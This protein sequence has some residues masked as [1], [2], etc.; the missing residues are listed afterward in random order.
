MASRTPCNVWPEKGFQLYIKLVKLVRRSGS[1]IERNCLSRQ[2]KK[3]I[4]PTK[5][6]P[7]PF[8]RGAGGGGKKLLGEMD[9]LIRLYLYTEVHHR[10]SGPTVCLFSN[11][12]LLCGIDTKSLHNALH[13]LLFFSLAGTKNSTP[14]QKQFYLCISSPTLFHTKRKTNSWISDF[15]FGDNIR[16]LFRYGRC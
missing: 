11:F 16:R 3:K 6:T 15:P 4:Y 14:G 13:L 8:R 5:K 1:S 2:T 12:H 7:L 10:H 9:G